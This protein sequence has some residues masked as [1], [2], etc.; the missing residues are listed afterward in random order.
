MYVSE[1]DSLD[2]NSEEEDSEEDFETSSEGSA[3]SIS[4][5]DDGGSQMDSQIK[6]SQTKKSRFTA[7]SKLSDFDISLRFN[8]LRFLAFN[9]KQ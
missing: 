1:M 3:A 5:L 9:L 2:L 4:V 8:A 7:G 6:F